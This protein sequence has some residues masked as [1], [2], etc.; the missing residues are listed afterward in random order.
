MDYVKQA[1]PSKTRLFYDIDDLVDYILKKQRND[2]NYYVFSSRL[3]EGVR[4]RLGG[5][6]YL[7]LPENLQ[8][9]SHLRDE[10]EKRQREGG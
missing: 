6:A 2:D 1:V 9:I 3:P 8:T 7:D 4:K 10:I 5:L